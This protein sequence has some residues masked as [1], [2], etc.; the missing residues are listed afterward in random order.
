ML[1][2]LNCP[3]NRTK[4]NNLWKKE[5]HPCDFIAAHWPTIY[6]WVSIGIV[7]IRPSLVNGL[8]ICSYSRAWYQARGHNT[9]STIDGIFRSPKWG[10][11][12][13]IL[14]PPTWNRYHRCVEITVFLLNMSLPN[15]SMMSSWTLCRKRECRCCWMRMCPSGVEQDAWS[16]N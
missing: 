2:P 12:W 15:A 9:R 5:T 8:Q 10:H 4:V 13:T 11:H 16:T 7:L 6:A 14:A 1:F 3:E